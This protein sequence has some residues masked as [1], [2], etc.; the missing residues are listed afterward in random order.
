MSRF[1]QPGDDSWRDP[2]R[3]GALR[4]CDRC[5]EAQFDQAGPEEYLI[6]FL[7]ERCLSELLALHGP[8][9]HVVPERPKRK[10]PL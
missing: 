9:T 7:C 3:K 2:I 10:R 1:D 5:G 6:R 4:R 8:H